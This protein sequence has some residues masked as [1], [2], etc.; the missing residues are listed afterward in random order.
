MTAMLPRQPAQALQIQRLATAVGS[1]SATLLLTL[2]VVHWITSAP[3][4]NIQVEWDDTI[5]EKA[6][7]ELEHRFQLLNQ[8][9]IRD[10]MW[11]Y[12]LI[13]ASTSNIAALVNNPAI[14]STVFL[15]RE[16]LSVS[17]DAPPGVITTWV[18]DRIPILNR[19]G[20]IRGVALS[21]FAMVVGALMIF[22]ATLS[23][24]GALAGPAHQSGSLHY[25]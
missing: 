16:A 24:P 12:D 15:D 6:R 18:G 21:L 3:A 23:K 13:D 25:G 9:A 22:F 10:R 5:S 4:P 17:P 20:V 14:V 19:P 11:S 1:L 2:L 8:A 7:R